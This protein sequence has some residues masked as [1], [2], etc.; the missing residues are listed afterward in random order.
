MFGNGYLVHGFL[1]IPQTSL[2]LDKHAFIV[3]GPATWN[4][5]PDDVRSM[6]TLD[7]FKQ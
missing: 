1:F 5:L 4:N 7:E 6:P 2:E 3:A